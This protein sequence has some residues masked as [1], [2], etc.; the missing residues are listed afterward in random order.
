MPQLQHGRYAGAAWL[1]RKAMNPLANRLFFHLFPVGK[2]LLLHEIPEGRD[3]FG[4]PQFLGIGE[5]NR[6]L[7]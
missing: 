2:Y 6:H 4:V 7:A 3:A 1:K 5:E